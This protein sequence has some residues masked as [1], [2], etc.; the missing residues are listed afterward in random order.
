MDGA[1]FELTYCSLFAPQ[2]HPPICAHAVPVCSL[3]S[4][5]AAASSAVQALVDVGYRLTTGQVEAMRPSGVRLLRALLLVFSNVEDPLLPGGG[6]EAGGHE[7]AAGGHE[8]G[9]ERRPCP[10]SLSRVCC[11]LAV[12]AVPQGRA[13]WSSTR[14]SW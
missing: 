6:G 9:A 7:S 11:R 4:S 1:H 10:E 5:A 13:S 12:P 14:R 3:F 2:A 8:H